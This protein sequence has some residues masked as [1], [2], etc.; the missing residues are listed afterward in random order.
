MTERIKA[1]DKR[2]LTVYLPEAS[3]KQLMYHCIDT[4]RSAS[5][6][7]EELVLAYL[8]KLPKAKARK[9]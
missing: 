9:E 2:K 6:I 5:S 7:L 3:Y 1:R 8:E 4:D